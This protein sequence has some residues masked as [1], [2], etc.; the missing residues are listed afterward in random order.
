MLCIKNLFFFSQ[1][2]EDALDDDVEIKPSP[3]L[4]NNSANN[5][6]GFLRTPEQPKSSSS[7]SPKTKSKFRF[8]RKSRSATEEIPLGEALEDAKISVDLFL[9]NNYEEA[10]NI[11]KPL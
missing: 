1:V 5:N 7:K 8:P 11:V 6:N 2:F 3:P 10:K 4:V 9:N